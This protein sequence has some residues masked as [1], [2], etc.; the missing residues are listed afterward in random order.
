M[1]RSRGSEVHV[2]QKINRL[3]QSQHTILLIGPFL[4]LAD[5]PTLR[6]LQLKRLISP[7]MQCFESMNSRSDHLPIAGQVPLNMAAIM[8]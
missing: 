5:N 4:E 8:A 7:I 1:C 6:L 2:G 3:R